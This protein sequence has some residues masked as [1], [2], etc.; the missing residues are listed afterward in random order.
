[1]VKKDIGCNSSELTF[2]TMLR[3]PEKF[4]SDDDKT[5]SLTEYRRRLVT[6]M[7]SFNP[8]LPRDP[9]RRSSYLDKALRT[10]THNFARDDGSAT[11]LQPAYT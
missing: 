2:G 8:S 10:C 5:V 9:C 4:F 3:L 7:K 1:M 6:F 11:S